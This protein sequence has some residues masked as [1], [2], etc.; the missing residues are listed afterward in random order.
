M[1][2]L[3]DIE[4]NVTGKIAMRAR[5]DWFWIDDKN[6]LRDSETKRIISTKKTIKTI[7][8]GISEYDICILSSEDTHT[9]LNLV[10]RLW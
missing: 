5:M 2:M 8:A 10:S 7:L 4:A 1:I 3:T 6:R 9:L